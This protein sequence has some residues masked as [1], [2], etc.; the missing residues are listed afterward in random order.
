MSD[1]NRCVIMRV[2][3]AFDG[4]AAYELSESLRHA[5]IDADVVIDFSR[6]EPFDSALATFFEDGILNR[7]CSVMVKGLSRHHHR[8]LRYLDLPQGEPA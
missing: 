3:G 1:A 2:E 6:A 5:P 4:Y 7:F 8:L